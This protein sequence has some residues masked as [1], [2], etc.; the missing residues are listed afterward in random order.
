MVAKDR[1]VAYP[2]EGTWADIGTVQAYWEANL[3]LLDDPNPVNLS[4]PDWPIV[5]R[6]EPRPP[7]RLGAQSVVHDALLSDGCEIRGTVIHSVLSPGVIVEAGAVVRNAVIL[8]D[9]AV[10]P[11]AVVDRCVVDEFVRIGAGARVG[12][13]A[14]V[15]AGDDTPPN[16]RE[17]DHL[18]TGITLVGKGAIIPGDA[19]IGRNCRID[20]HTT[21][22][23]YDGREVPSGGTVSRRE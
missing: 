1:V 7:T 16:Q 3:A 12:A 13:G 9:T 19:V 23:D 8:H 5:T 4:D 2:F 22:A 15:G 21:P 6:A 10:G 11:G 20:P 14:D 17:P 18:T